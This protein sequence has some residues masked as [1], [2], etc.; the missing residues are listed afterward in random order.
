[1]PDAIGRRLA[2]NELST[3]RWSFE[4]DV[5]QYKAHG[6]A[7]IGV[8]R[9]KVSDYG[10]EKAM[11]L[12]SE[13][14]L[15]V[16]SLQWA[17]GFTGSDGRSFREAMHDAFDA[18]ELA[19][20]LKAQTLVVLTGSRSGHTRNHA[21]RILT[22]ALRELA[23]AGRAKGVQIAIEP[24]HYGCAHEW[25]FL[26]DIPQCLDII[27]SIDDPNLGIVFDCYHM[28]Q[29]Q[30][31]VNWLPSIV[32][33]VRLVQLGDAKGA[34]VGEQNRCQLGQ[35]LIPLPEIVR[36]FEENNYKG[37]YEIELLGQEVEHEEY[38]NV[39]DVAKRNVVEMM[40]I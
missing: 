21:K 33:M 1:M 19:A 37:F 27:A 9:A 15:R 35:G 14:E 2:V 7:A 30:D 28:A 29:D 11:E 40:S 39:L 12:I 18:I 17:G 31:V 8:W 25:T 38:G 4:E 16:S 5:I 20:S 23:E 10:D 26:T 36:T 32:P 13:H 24:M 6:F 22:T 3:Y 34:P